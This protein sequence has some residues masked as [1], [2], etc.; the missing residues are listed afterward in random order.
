MQTMKTDQRSRLKPWTLKG[1]GKTERKPRKRGSWFQRKT[2]RV[3]C[4]GGKHILEGEHVLTVKFNKV[5]ALNWPLDL[6]TGASCWLCKSNFRETVRGEMPARVCPWE[7]WGREIRNNDYRH[8][9][10]GNLRSSNGNE[11]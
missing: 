11:A 6:T 8:L 2:R 3:S 1:L 9:S 7:K 10:E 4:P 5:M